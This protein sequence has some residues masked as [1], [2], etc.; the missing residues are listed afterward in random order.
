[1]TLFWC[2]ACLV[3]QNMGQRKPSVRETQHWS[4]VPDPVKTKCGA[5]TLL[6]ALTLFGHTGAVNI[7]SSSTREHLNCLLSISLRLAF[8]LQVSKTN[9]PVCCLVRPVWW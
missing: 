1:M 9:P 4:L 6:P 3:F 2:I 7:L 8:S 5:V